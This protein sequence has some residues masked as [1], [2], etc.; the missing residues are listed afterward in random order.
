MSDISQR[1]KNIIVEH[2]GVDAAKVTDSASFIDDLGVDSLDLVEMVMKF[3]TEFGVEIT[4][5]TTAQLTTVKAA[6]D[7]IASQGSAA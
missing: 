3:E 4:E 5:K 7:Y 6:I 2:L 1:V